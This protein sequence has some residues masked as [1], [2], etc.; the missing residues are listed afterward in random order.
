MGAQLITLV[1]IAYVGKGSGV[2]S[3]RLG[4]FYDL[5]ACETAARKAELVGPE[6]DVHVRFV[7]AYLTPVSTNSLQPRR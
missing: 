5:P 6:T 1:M 7:C 3:Q 2:T 4:D